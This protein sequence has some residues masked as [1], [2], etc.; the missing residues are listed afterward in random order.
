MYIESDVMK[1]GPKKFDSIDVF[2]N[3]LLYFGIQ[4]YGIHCTAL[5]DFVAV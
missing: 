2:W 1:I 5:E 4:F 3:T